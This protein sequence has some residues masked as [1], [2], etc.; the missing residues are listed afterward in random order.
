MCC[1]TLPMVFSVSWR[2]AYQLHF[3]Y[4]I[5]VV[6]DLV[7]SI[8]FITRFLFASLKVLAQ[9]TNG[10]K[11]S[12][13]SHNKDFEYL[14]IMPADGH[15]VFR[16]VIDLQ[17]ESHWLAIDERIH[18]DLPSSLQSSTALQADICWTRSLDTDFFITIQSRNERWLMTYMALWCSELWKSLYIRID[19]NSLNNYGS[20]D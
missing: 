5:F 18:S 14:Y 7:A 3:A 2:Y 16:C 10:W 15:W 8:P 6:S 1:L 13:Q 4:G 19:Q 17:S 9:S 11:L 20:N 12:Y